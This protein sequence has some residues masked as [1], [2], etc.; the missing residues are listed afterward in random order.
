MNPAY[1]IFHKQADSNKQLYTLLRFAYNCN[2]V[3]ALSLNTYESA[4]AFLTAECKVSRVFNVTDI[5]SKIVD[6]YNS[7]ASN[8]NVD[9]KIEK[10]S[11]TIEPTEL[12]YINTPAEGNYRAMELTKYSSKVSKYIILPNTVLHAHQASTNIK[13]DDNVKPIGIVFGI[14]H[15]LQENDNWFILEHDEVSP[16][17]TVLVNKD[18]VSC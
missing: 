17:V 12:L 5:D 6:A 7:I 2:H 18:N 10:L 9:F 8:L 15:F 16:G 13:L 14:N 3:T 1:E 11:E 4:A